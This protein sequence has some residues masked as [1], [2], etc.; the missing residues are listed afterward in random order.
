MPEYI[1]SQSSARRKAKPGMEILKLSSQDVEAERQCTGT[2]IPVSVCSFS[3]LQPF[4]SPTYTD[5]TSLEHEVFLPQL[6]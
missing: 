3:H 1:H 4:E 2:K 6:L 5:Y